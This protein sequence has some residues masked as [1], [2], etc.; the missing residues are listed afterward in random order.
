[1]MN[2]P[3]LAFWIREYSHPG[4]LISEALFVLKNSGNGRG[5]ES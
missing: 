5:R 3:P 4:A 2:F 1:M